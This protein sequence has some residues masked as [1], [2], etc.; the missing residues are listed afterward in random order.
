[1]FLTGGA[2]K[3]QTMILN[4]RIAIIDLQ[5]WYQWRIERTLN[6]QNVMVKLSK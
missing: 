3:C 4:V 6:A 2:N 5:K 1:M